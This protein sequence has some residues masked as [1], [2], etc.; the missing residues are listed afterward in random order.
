[1][2]QFERLTHKR[3]I[4]LSGTNNALSVFQKFI[5][6]AGVKVEFKQ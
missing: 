2:E 1:M 3:L 5:P 6:P 4:I